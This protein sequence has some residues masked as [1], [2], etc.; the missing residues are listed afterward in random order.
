[1]H[2]KLASITLLLVASA[3]ALVGCSDSSSETIA[4]TNPPIDA[5]VCDGDAGCESDMRDLSHKLVD[6]DDANGDGVI[7]QEELD[8]AR[9]RM[10]K[11]AAEQAASESS[12]AAAA[13]ES[14]AAEASRSAQA[15]EEAEQSAA[16]ASEAAAAEARNQQ[17]APEPE[18]APAPVQEAPQQEAPA[19]QA[20]VQQA[21]A[22]PAPQQGG[23]SM[24]W[25]TMG[26]YASEWTCEQARS[27]WPVDSSACYTGADGSAYFEGM[28]QAAQ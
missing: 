13:S 3:A 10:D 11:E 4:G 9:D 22:Q 7:D 5:T 26:P 18:P 24:E 21:P 28:R 14:A 19:Q 1:M 23:P 27:L 6:A 2:K 25:A 12:A 17:Q 15:R 20:P 16:A 8:A